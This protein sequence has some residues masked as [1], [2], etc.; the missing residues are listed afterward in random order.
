MEKSDVYFSD[1]TT[2]HFAIVTLGFMIREYKK[3]V[4]VKLGNS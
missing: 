1:G 3:N 2:N 4:K